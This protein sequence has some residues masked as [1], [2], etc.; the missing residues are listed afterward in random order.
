MRH[1]FAF[2]A[3]AVAGQSSVEALVITAALVLGAGSLA[4]FGED[5]GL[6]QAW[7]DALRRFHQ[8]FAH[9]VSLPG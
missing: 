7:I 3:R 8:G 2:T 6:A 1:G 9:A 4:L 5:G